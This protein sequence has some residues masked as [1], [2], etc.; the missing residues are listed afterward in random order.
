ISAFLSDENA[1]HNF[2]RQ[3]AAFLATD[4]Y[5]GLMVDFETFPKLAQPGYVALLRE[6]SQDLHAKGMKLY[7]S[8]QARSEDYDYPA[9]TTQVDGIVLMNYDEHYP[10][11]GTAGPV[12]SQDWF[13]ENL[14][15]AKKVIPQ[16]KLICAIANYG[17]DWVRKPKRGPLPAGAKDI[18]VSVQ[19]SWLTARDSEEDIDF[20]GDSQN[21]HIAYL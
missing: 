2:R 1:R 18:S 9:I 20:D 12:A 8:L 16:D 5:R 7:V 14:E 3:V 11:P 21:P 19:D 10:S 15:A 6:L 17:Y 4:K 13:V